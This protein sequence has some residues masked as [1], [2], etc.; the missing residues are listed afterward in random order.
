MRKRVAQS[1][2]RLHSDCKLPVVSRSVNLSTPKRPRGAHFVVLSN[3]ACKVGHRIR[4]S[5]VRVRGFSHAPVRCSDWPCARRSALPSV[6]SGQIVVP[7]KRIQD[8]QMFGGQKPSS[9][10]IQSRNQQF[11]R[12]IIF[13]RDLQKLEIPWILFHPLSSHVW[14]TS[15]VCLLEEQHRSHSI[16]F[17]QCAFGTPWKRRTKLIAV[18]CN[19]ES[20][21]SLAEYSCEGHDVCPSVGP[22]IQLHGS[23]LSGRQFTA[24]CKVLPHRL[25]SKLCI[26][27]SCPEKLETDET[28]LFSFKHVNIRLLRRSGMIWDLVATFEGSAI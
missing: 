7:H 2:L 13:I 8:G 23:D 25:C 26:F 10:H 28:I 27:F 15:P 11:K 18:N 14:S 1:D 22:H 21:L 3:A 24:R 5:H 17:D 19:Y 12:V 9:P 6:S 4:Q 20:I 16:I